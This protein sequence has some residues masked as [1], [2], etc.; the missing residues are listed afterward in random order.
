MVTLVLGVLGLRLWPDLIALLV[1]SYG[2]IPMCLG[3]CVKCKLNITLREMLIVWWRITLP[4]PLSPS[5]MERQSLYSIPALS[6]STSAPA[7]KTPELSLGPPCS[8][9]GTGNLA[10]VSRHK[11]CLS[12]EYHIVTSK[13]TFHHLY[14]SANNRPGNIYPGCIEM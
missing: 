14:Y 5:P 11:E 9:M 13:V 1:M 2:M 6:T 3:T 8:S 4:P 7:P 10:W 12:W